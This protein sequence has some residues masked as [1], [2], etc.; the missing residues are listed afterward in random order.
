[1]AIETLTPAAQPVAS[2]LHPLHVIYELLA[3]TGHP[4]SLT[5]LRRWRKHYGLRTVRINRAHYVSLTDVLE[6]HRDLVLKRDG[7]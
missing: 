7:F 6:L 5:T 1:M 4:V 2:D 3:E